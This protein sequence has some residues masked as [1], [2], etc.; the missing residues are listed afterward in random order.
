MLYLDR[1]FLK[2][3]QGYSLI[4][5]HCKCLHLHAVRDFSNREIVLKFSADLL[6]TEI[7]GLLIF[8]LYYQIR[9]IMGVCEAHQCDVCKPGLLSFYSTKKVAG[10]FPAIQIALIFMNEA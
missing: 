7:P 1:K 8:L 10:K 4:F 3:Q 6:G 5:F 9:A 2:K